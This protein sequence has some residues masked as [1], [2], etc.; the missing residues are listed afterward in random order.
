MDHGMSEIAASILLSLLFVWWTTSPN[1][2]E[3]AAR[4][5]Q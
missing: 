1:I 3:A 5:P 2:Y 4:S